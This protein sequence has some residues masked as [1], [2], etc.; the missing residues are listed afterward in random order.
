[1]AIQ[2]K[3]YYEILGV[4][5]QA[6]DD[7]VRRA[8]RKLARVYHP[9]KT[10]NDRRA[11]DRFKEVNEAYEVLG[12][13]E[14]RQRYDEFNSAW[15]S[16]SADEAWER[17]SRPEGFAS[18][19]RSE[20]FTFTGAGFSDFFEQLFGQRPDSN[21]GA[22]PARPPADES[23]G[24]GDD[25][26]ADI[27]VSLDE[28]ARGAVRPIEMRRAARCQKCFG[29]G[30]YNAHR[31]EECQGAG[32]IPS[33]VA[34]KVK[35]PPGVREGALLR[36]LGRGEEGLAGTP[37][38][39]LYLKVRYAPHREFQFE[40][41][42]LT[43]ELEIAPWEAVLG[44]SVSIPTING[45]VSIK[46]PPGSQTGRKLRVRGHGLPAAEGGAGDLLVKLKVQVPT[47]APPREL[48]LWR[49]LARESTFQPRGN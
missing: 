27:W 19:G 36:V 13:R 26:E 24:R 4:S 15:Q 35:I 44:T 34:C 2:F 40:R 25:L 10:G 3:D 5:R 47:S 8:F 14:K 23:A 30:Q 32:N 33:T 17:F 18:G 29:M 28:V 37:P 16:S 20:H 7:E 42:H 45:R 11:E 38:G 46:V 49:E 6:G 1:M 48:D 31:C 39:D 43:H 41:G 9:D 12:D 22:Q 21:R